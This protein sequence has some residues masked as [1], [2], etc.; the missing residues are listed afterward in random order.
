MNYGL[1]MGAVT[2]MVVTVVAMVFLGRWLD[3]TMGYDSLFLVLGALVG[4]VLG[5]YRLY[6]KLVKIR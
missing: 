2:E 6:Q 4:T 5:F 1:V 3:G